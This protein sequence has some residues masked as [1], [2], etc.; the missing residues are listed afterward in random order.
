MPPLLY[1]RSHVA[2]RYKS[3]VPP[4]KWRE[5]PLQH[6]LSYPA[7]LSFMPTSS[8]QTYLLRIRSV[9]VVADEGFHPVHPGQCRRQV[10]DRSS[11]VDFQSHFD[12]PICT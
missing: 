1:Q 11:A 12:H 6:Y 5:A 10:V 2:F 8:W 3:L 4:F 7:V 9:G